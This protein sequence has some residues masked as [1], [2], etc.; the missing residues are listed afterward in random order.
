M[1]R[2][3][4]CN[5]VFNDQ[6]TFCLTDGTTLAVDY[7][8]EETPTIVR[9][10]VPTFAGQTVA[11]PS[12][13][14]LR[15]VIPA[16]LGLVV[17]IIGGALIGILIY[18]GLSQKDETDAANARSDNEITRNTDLPSSNLEMPDNEMTDEVNDRE[19]ELEEREANLN[20]EKKRLEDEK[21]KIEEKKKEP[22]TAPIPKSEQPNTRTARVFDPPSNI[23]VTPNGAIQCVIRSP[24]NVAILG[25][26]GVRDNNGSWYYTNAC[27]RTG[28]IHSTQ[29]RF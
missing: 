25:P 13:N 3:P 22:E 5:Q 23:R 2:C 26:T 6:Y 29:I 7:G 8:E 14:P 21:K 20:R 19:R 27:G 18:F 11:E 24:R 10:T 4:R 12:R 28:V 16:V 15:F 9:Q 1:K 17:L